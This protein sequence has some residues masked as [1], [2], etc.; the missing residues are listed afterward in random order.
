[1]APG[2]LSAQLQQLRSQANAS[3]NRRSPRLQRNRRSG[4]VL[5]LLASLLCL[6]AAQEEKTGYDIKMVGDIWPMQLQEDEKRQGQPT[7]I[8]EAYEEYEIDPA[9]VAK[10]K[11]LGDF[12]KGIHC[13][14]YNDLQRITFRRIQDAVKA[15]GIGVVFKEWDGMDDSV[16]DQKLNWKEL[17]M[18]LRSLELYDPFGKQVL[19]SVQEVEQLIREVTD[20]DPAEFVAQEWGSSFYRTDGTDTDALTQHYARQ[21]RTLMDG[22]TDNAMCMSVAGEDLGICGFVRLDN[23]TRTMNQVADIKYSENCNGHGICD[24]SVGVCHCQAGW[25]G[26]NCSEPEKPCGGIITLEKSY[27]S[28]SDGYGI[29]REYANSINCTWIIRPEYHSTY[30]LPIVFTFVFYNMEAGFDAVDLYEMPFV[31]INFKLKALGVGGTFPKDRWAMPHSVVVGNG[32]SV[33]INFVSDAGNPSGTYYGFK[34]LF[35]RLDATYIKALSFPLVSPGC[36]RRL[37]AESPRCLDRQCTNCGVTLDEDADDAIFMGSPENMCFSSEQPSNT[38]QF[39]IS[40]DY[41]TCAEVLDNIWLQHTAGETIKMRVECTRGFMS[42]PADFMY[43]L[44][45]YVLGSGPPEVR[46]PTPEEGQAFQRGYIPLDWWG[47][48]SFNC[49]GMRKTD[50]FNTLFEDI[51]GKPGPIF[52]AQI[53]AKESNRAR[54]FEGPYVTRPKSRVTGLQY[55]NDPNSVDNRTKDEKNSMMLAQLYRP[56]FTR[57]TTETQGAEVELGQEYCEFSFTP[58]IP[59]IYQVNFFEMRKDRYF[60]KFVQAIPFPQAQS[61][62]QAVIMPAKTSPGNSR[63]YGQGLAYYQ[64]TRTG[65]G[66]SFMIDSLDRFDNLRLTGGDQYIVALVHQHQEGYK[67]AEVSNLGN[68]S[69]FVVFNVTLSG[70]YS[71][72]ITLPAQADC[73]NPRRVSLSRPGG[74]GT[75]QMSG[76]RCDLGTAFTV[77]RNKSAGGRE[78]LSN[79]TEGSGPVHWC[80]PVSSQAA[81]EAGE[82]NCVEYT[83]HLPGQAWI[84]FKSPFSV[85]VDSGPITISSVK[86]FGTGLSMGIANYPAFFMLRI[87][88]VFGNWATSLENITTG[89]ELPGV[90]QSMFDGSTTPTSYESLYAGTEAFTGDYAGEWVPQLAGMHRVSVMLC[91]PFCTHIIGSPYHAKVHPAPTYGP[92]STAHGNGI[93]DGFAGHARSFEIQDR[94]SALNRRRDGGEDFE[95]SLAGLSLSDCPVIQDQVLLDITRKCPDLYRS[96]VIP[97]NQATKQNMPGPEVSFNI[98]PSLTCLYRRNTADCHPGCCPDG[99]ADACSQF[100]EKTTRSGFS[101][102]SIGCD[103]RTCGFPADCRF[104]MKKMQQQGLGGENDLLQTFLDA[105]WYRC[106]QVERLGLEARMRMPPDHRK[107]GQ[108][109]LQVSVPGEPLN[110]ILEP[111]R[112]PWKGPMSVFEIQNWISRHDLA[113]LYYNQTKNINGY[114]YFAAYGASTGPKENIEGFVLEVASAQGR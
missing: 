71:L 5:A 96:T 16:P 40:Q 92:N 103:V 7:T 99:A 106:P 13:A 3:H 12:D 30:G 27:G 10:F 87:R 67:Y 28:I 86:A 57:F 108:Y 79:A 44:P 66:A 109:N 107:D 25:T 11:A 9:M 33:A 94:D 61:H 6:S 51:P 75:R 81:K 105:A 64:T 53:T 43:D 24:L 100:D 82:E 15:R 21:P 93:M 74:K 104:A 85:W 35:G 29:G 54:Q 88:D 55:G 63:A 83:Y 8:Q 41:Y 52:V 56:S 45:E 113:F 62:R 47:G 42:P 32:K 68:G 69:Y 77:P 49:N 102:N 97:C 70:R 101:P 2:W 111:D 50:K 48:C 110:S 18:G 80:T 60:D 4:A 72:S 78:I 19:L 89:F 59:G 14:G 84:P 39:A 65:V 76:P 46:V 36:N 23:F 112:P 17:R 20:D 26:F 38:T 95:V 98:P 37:P 22:G 34:I 31:D 91:N 73:P 1:M 58:T 90:A 114:G